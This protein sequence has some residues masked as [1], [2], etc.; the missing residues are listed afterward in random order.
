MLPA[1]VLCPKGN[2]RVSQL[3]IERCY[4]QISLLATLQ[5]LRRVTRP[6]NAIADSLLRRVPDFTLFHAQHSHQEQLNGVN[7]SEFVK[8]W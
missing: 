2:A 3:G 1:A 5:V 7:N 4:N 6:P 8:C